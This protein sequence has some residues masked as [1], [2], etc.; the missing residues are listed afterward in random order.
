MWISQAVF[1]ISSHE[2]LRGIFSDAVI[3]LG[4]GVGGTEGFA[5]GEEVQFIRAEWN[6]YK[7]SETK[8]AQKLSEKQKYDALL[9][10]SSSMATVH[11]CSWWRLLVGI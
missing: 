6:G 11:L 3:D 2:I 7:I 1:P 8:Q 5:F 10:D 9:R 4:N